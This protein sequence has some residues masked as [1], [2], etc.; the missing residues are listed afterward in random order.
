VTYRRGQGRVFRRGGRWW[1]AYY[2][3]GREIRESSRTDNEQVAARLLKDRLAAIY[4]GSFV[5]PQQARVTVGEL[6][7]TLRVEMEARGLKG[8]YAIKG[9]F[10]RLSAALGHHRAAALTPEMLLRYDLALR[11]KGLAPS[12]RQSYLGLLKSAF[13]VG[14]RHRRI[15]LVPDFPRLGALRNARRGFVEPEVFA[16]ILPNLPPIGREIATFAYAS[17]WRQA[18]VLGLTWDAVDRRSQEIRL[19]D[20]KNDRPRLLALT[21][22][23]TKLIERRWR[24][25]AVGDRMARWVFHHRG[26]RP[27][28]PTALRK[29]WRTATAAAGHP[30]VLFHDLRRSGVRNLIRAGVSEPVAMS[31]SGHESAAIFRRYNI[32]S[33]DDQRRALAATQAYAVARSRKNRRSSP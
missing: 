5:G 11:D 19:A 8:W 16:E 13:K 14:V 27:V 15:A 4:T 18:E 7:E 2:H 20:T 23:L 26:G 30:G 3:E 1:I 12:T 9:I 31:I 28:S 17:A 33:V 32:T 29:W 25:R 6:I 10:P 24:R 22:D 21:G